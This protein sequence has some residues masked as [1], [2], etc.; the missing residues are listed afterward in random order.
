MIRPAN[1]RKQ[2]ARRKEEIRA[3]PVQPRL[4]ISTTCSSISFAFLLH[5]KRPTPLIPSSVTPLSCGSLPCCLPPPPL[6]LRPRPLLARLVLQHL[7]ARHDVGREAC[8]DRVRDLQV[9]SGR[10]QGLVAW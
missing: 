6:R 5:Q 7:P 10:V 2:G 9:G 4:Y 8:V 3:W 1:E